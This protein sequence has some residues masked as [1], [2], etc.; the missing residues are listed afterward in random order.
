[1]MPV[2]LD[3]Q[4][5]YIRNKSPSEN[6][7]DVERCLAAVD[8]AAAEHN[9]VLREHFPQA[10]KD[11]LAS[12]I[13]HESPAMPG[14]MLVGLNLQSQF[15]TSKSPD[16]NAYDM[17]AILQA[18]T[19]ALAEHNLVL[20]EHWPAL[21]D[22]YDANVKYKT[23]P[24][25]W[26]VQTLKSIPTIKEQGGSDCKNLVGWRLAHMWRDELARLGRRLSRCKI[27]WRFLKPDQMLRSLP[28]PVLDRMLPN[29]RNL[30][31]RTLYDAI[32]QFPPGRLFHAEMRKPDSP[33]GY[34]TPDGEVE[35]MS[36]YLGM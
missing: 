1:M 2:L 14:I 25:A 30:D 18:A 31:A 6:H 16:E 8:K 9:R 19:H 3:V 33:T 4:T 36:R 27:Y 35:D 12:P 32:A 10:S 26:M 7:R 23:D 22:L 11:L 21:P 34:T 17:A 24:N 15:I 28:V 29:W 20:L 13:I 5:R